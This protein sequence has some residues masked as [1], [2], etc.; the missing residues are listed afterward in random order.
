MKP[1]DYK[2]FGIISIFIIII[3]CAPGPLMA[4]TWKCQ[5]LLS[6]QKVL[7]DETSRAKLIFITTH[8]GRDTNLYFHDRCWLL[9]GEL[10]LFYSDRMGRSEIFGYV[11]ATGELIRL[12]KKE[13][14]VARSAVAS[15]QGDK[16]YVVRKNTI[17]QWNIAVLHSPG[18]LVTISE[19]RLCDF[20]EGSKQFSGLSENADGTLVS[21]GYI[22]DDQYTIAVVNTMSGKTEV[23]A[24]PNLP[25]QH[26]QFSWNRPDLI[27]FSGNYG[28]DWAPLDPEVPPHARIWYVNVNLK[29]PLAAFYQKPG[30]LATHECWWIN[31]QITFIGGHRRDEGHV[32]VLDFKTGEIRI[33]GAGAWWAEGTEIELARVNWWHAAGSPDGRF[34]A[35][36]N[37]HGTIALFDART[38]EMRILTQE[39][40]IYGSGAHP[41]VGWDLFG[42]SVE[43]TSN[44]FGN[45]D[46]CIAIIPENW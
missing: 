31:D 30:E 23:V 3:V 28:G 42:K 2:I 24:Q 6:E 19:N 46:V 22:I 39:H 14:R 16:L 17:Y 18:T 26:I 15:R 1:Y 32:K 8:K 11:A 43:F 27:S 7:F 45:P 12:N 5:V 40:R 33:I 13:D 36:D 41:H 20:P 10:M 9:D 35:A 25:I 21:F 37:W 4:R 34:V 29:T 44:K 38:T